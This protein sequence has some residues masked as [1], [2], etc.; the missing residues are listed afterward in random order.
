[1]TYLGPCN[2]AATEERIHHVSTMY[3]MV[4]AAEYCWVMVIVGSHMLLVLAHIYKFRSNL[5]KYKIPYNIVL[6]DISSSPET[7]LTTTMINH[8]EPP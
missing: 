7:W 1:M 4:I 6:V 5:D 2:K 3:M 8:Y